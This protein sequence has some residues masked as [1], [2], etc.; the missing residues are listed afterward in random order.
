MVNL[1]Q[2]R[3]RQSLNGLRKRPR[4]V[5]HR[6]SHIREDTGALDEIGGSLSGKLHGEASKIIIAFR[7]GLSIEETFAD[8]FGLNTDKRVD[9]PGIT[10]DAEKLRVLEARFNGID[11][12]DR[13]TILVADGALVPVIRDKFVT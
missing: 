11:V 6:T 13:D 3:A 8:V 12:E 7:Q 5:R 9:F 4:Q 1:R 2:L 10:T